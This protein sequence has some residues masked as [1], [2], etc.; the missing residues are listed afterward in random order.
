MRYK[1]PPLPVD[2]GFAA[3]KNTAQATNG[4]NPTVPFDTSYTEEVAALFEI[5]K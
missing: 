5:R 3:N 4:W 1:S 2:L